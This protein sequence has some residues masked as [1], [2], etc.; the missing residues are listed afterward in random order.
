MK[1]FK[2]TDLEVIS[3]RGRKAR[4]EPL[5]TKVEAD[6]FGCSVETIRKILRGDTFRHL[7]GQTDS[8]R[9]V[10]PEVSSI[11]ESFARLRGSLPE[12][13]IQSILGKS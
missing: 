12:E 9:S 6:K 2:L 3:L 11:E 7:L 4:G 8:P 1:T 5:N 10:E 13:D